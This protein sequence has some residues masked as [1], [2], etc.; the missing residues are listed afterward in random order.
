MID[1]IKKYSILLRFILMLLIVLGIIKSCSNAYTWDEFV[2]FCS[3]AENVGIEGNALTYSNLIKNNYSLIENNFNNLG[4]DLDNFNNFL[5]LFSYGDRYARLYVFNNDVNIQYQVLVGGDS[6]RWQVS[7]LANCYRCNLTS[8]Y[9]VSENTTNVFYGDR[10]VVGLVDN[11]YQFLTEIDY[12]AN[13]LNYFSININDFRGRNFPIYFAD[14]RIG[15]FFI[16]NNYTFYIYDSSV[17][18]PIRVINT[19]N[20]VGGRLYQ[21]EMTTS[22]LYKLVSGNSYRLCYGN[23]D[24][25]IYSSDY[26]T[27]F[28]RNENNFAPI[29]TYSR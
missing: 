3:N 28:Y 6:F 20:V 5:I 7:G 29:I 27:I 26:F 4:L 18:L 13:R 17:F 14:A 19:F 1:K 11:N 23:I 22:T 21:L 8:S 25:I 9:Y 12:M 2:E 24:N 10:S 15:D 16:N